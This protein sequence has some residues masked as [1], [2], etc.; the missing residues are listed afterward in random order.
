MRQCWSSYPFVDD[1]RMPTL[2]AVGDDG[3][4]IATL[5]SV[6]QHTETLGFNGDATERLWY[7]ADWP[8]FFRQSLEQRYGGVAIEMAGS[9]G[10][11]ESPE[12]FPR[13]SLS[14]RRSSRRRA[15]RPAAA[16]CSTRAAPRTSRSA[17]TRRP[18]PTASSWPPRSSRAWTAA[19]RRRSRARSRARAPT[20]ACR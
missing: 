10:S 11:V 12:V 18:R 1:M 6:S 15:T 13:R 19:R 2:Q 9:V 16:P 5:A 7:T 14:S 8:Q 20:S 3:K 4:T 17:T